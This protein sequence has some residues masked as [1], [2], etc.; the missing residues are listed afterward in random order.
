MDIGI[1]L[2][3]NAVAIGTAFAPWAQYQTK[4][5][6]VEQL[7]GTST[8]ANVLIASSAI[9]I[10]CALVLS[11]GSAASMI[12]FVASVVSFVVAGATWMLINSV[13]VGDPD[14][15]SLPT[16]DWG[17]IAGTLGALLASVFAFRVMC[18][19]RLYD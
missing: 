15:P 13:Y 5:E 19:V 11:N 10:V 2:L 3:G 9:A 14:I 18:A 12:G 6:R 8:D 7:G 1:A 17:A 16:A 4:G